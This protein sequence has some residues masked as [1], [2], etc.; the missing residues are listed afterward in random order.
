MAL[1]LIGAVAD[2]A[3]PVEENSAAERI[4]LLTLVEADVAATA[5]LGVLQPLERKESPFQLSQFAQRERQA[6]LPG[7]GRELAQDHRSG[8]RSRFDRQGEAQQFEP[9]IANDAKIDGACHRRSEIGRY[10]HAG[11]YIKSLFLQVANAP[12][13][14]E[15]QQTAHGKDMIGE[16]A[17]V[18]VVLV[19]DEAALVIKQSVEDIGRLVSGRGDHLGVKGPKLIG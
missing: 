8:D 12:R 19:N 4:L 1:V 16:A 18:G 6:V 7:I 14:A 2:F 15:A 13:K 17:G 5:Q 10:G 11:Q 9:M 3:E